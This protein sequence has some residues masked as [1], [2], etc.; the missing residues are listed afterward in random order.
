[1]GACCDFVTEEEYRQRL[2][3]D[4]GTRK[5]PLVSGDVPVPSELPSWPG[6]AVE[7]L[8]ED[9]KQGIS[10]DVHEFA[11]LDDG[12]RLTLHEERGFTISL[13]ASTGSAPSDQWRYLTLDNLERDVLTTVLP[14]DD[15]TPD[16]H[17][18]EWLAG[19][20]HLHG[21]EETAE[22]L[23]SLPYIVVFSERLRARLAADA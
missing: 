4:G 14:D 15:G 18:W 5:E 3:R 1:L 2:V 8:V 17:P 10:F 12:R 19:L 23:R 21:V 22:E 20:L 7:N 9:F 16:Q 11:D 6:E 13:R